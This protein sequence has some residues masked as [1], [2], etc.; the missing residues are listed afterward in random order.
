[1]RL[2]LIISL[3]SLAYLVAG[4]QPTVRIGHACEQEPARVSYF[5]KDSDSD[6]YYMHWFLE[7]ESVHTPQVGPGELTNLD[8]GEYEMKFYTRENKEE[9]FQLINIYA[10]TF[11][12]V[13]PTFV[14]TI[15]NTCNQIQGD[16][17]ITIELDDWN[18]NLAGSYTAYL[19]DDNGQVVQSAILYTKN[20][21]FNNVS[22]GEYIVRVAPTYGGIVNTKK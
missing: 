3:L 13:E 12:Q 21:T 20:H 6:N 15:D 4:Q 1:M 10:Y 22:S 11:Y 19:V 5:V 2:F 17:S 16:V 14:W 7:G 18:S 9:S 8:P